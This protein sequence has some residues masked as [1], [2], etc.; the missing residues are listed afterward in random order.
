MAPQFKIYVKA[1]SDGQ[2]IGDCPFS[3][4]VSM[5]AH[6]KIPKDQ[7][8]LLPV[9]FS[10]KSKEFLQLNPEGSVPVLVDTSNN[11]VITNSPL[12]VKY[13]EEEFP[14]PDLRHSYQGPAAEACSG[15]FPKLVA[16]L[17]NKDK[18]AIPSLRKALEDELAKVD[19]YLKSA[20]C[21]GPFLLCDKVCA[22]DCSLLPKLRHVQVA[23]RH[24]QKF[25]I[26]KWLEAL[27]KYIQAGET[28]A[29]FQKTNY[30][31][32]E[33]IK[34][35]ERHGLMKID[36]LLKKGCGCF[37]KNLFVFWGEEG[38][39]YIHDFFY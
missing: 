24:F 4:Y 28:C 32:D 16:L 3:Q 26:P 19:S 8:T 38:L 33:I 10:N 39:L 23:G 1:A 5:V 37:Y 31:D 22:L 13:I 21:C 36:W 25:E 12:I 6:L 20:E 18:E 11:R 14:E 15:V 34:G 9:D 35:W 29:A 17:K 30:S 7:Y 2:S 27:H